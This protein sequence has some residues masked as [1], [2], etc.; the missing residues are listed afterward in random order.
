MVEKLKE[1]AGEPVLSKFLLGIIVALLG[2]NVH[3]T[4]QL[5]IDVAVIS[6]ELEALSRQVE[7]NRIT[8]QTRISRN[9]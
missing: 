5:T 9:D 8:L 7:Q 1:L 6:T 3:T 4:Q 2:W